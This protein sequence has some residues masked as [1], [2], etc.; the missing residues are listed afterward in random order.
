MVGPLRVDVE[1]LVKISE[2]RIDLGPLEETLGAIVIFCNQENEAR[3]EMNKKFKAQMNSL[4][5]RLEKMDEALKK[6]PMMPVLN[7]LENSHRHD[8]VD[9]GGHESH[10]VAEGTAQ[11]IS[12]SG[13]F[14]SPTQLRSPKGSASASSTATQG[15]N[16]A[17]VVVTASPRLLSPRAPH[18][19]ISPR[20]DEVDEEREAR[21]S[22]LE[23]SADKMKHNIASVDVVHLDQAVKALEDKHERLES[24]IADVD[25]KLHRLRAEQQQ[26]NED[27]SRIKQQLGDA[28]VQKMSRH[29]KE[30]LL[31]QATDE[32]ENAKRAQLLDSL[33]ES[34]ERLQKE[35]GDVRHQS[36][37]V[38]IQQLEHTQAMHTQQL[39]ELREDNDEQQALIAGSFAKIDKLYEELASAAADSEQR[40]ELQRQQSYRTSTTAEQTKARLEMM[41]EQ[42]QDFRELKEL[43]EVI[44]E[45][46]AEIPELKVARHELLAIQ[47][48]VEE[49]ENSQLDIKSLQRDV[50]DHSH[51]NQEQSKSLEILASRANAADQRFQSFAQSLLALHQ[52]LGEHALDLQWLFTQA[53]WMKTSL[54]E[55]QERAFVKLPTRP[56]SPQRLQYVKVTPA[57]VP[58]L[59]PLSA[60]VY[61]LGAM[62]WS[63]PEENAGNAAKLNRSVNEAI[64]PA[65]KHLGRPL[66][67]SS[68]RKPRTLC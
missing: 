4:E 59:P 37:G 60:E 26:D 43:S 6:R 12:N 53:R 42:M 10:D 62:K 50:M 33:L 29:V 66:S 1:D 22:V 16:A 30:L 36:A 20:Q 47:R 49:L 45:I 58:N 25:A 15:E 65:A 8:A 61:A 2:P 44:Y 19:Y 27:F 48:A 38:D 3:K 64:T 18:P 67:A 14:L 11:I 13:C 52:V 54:E 34:T 9:K 68:V 63:G 56:P 31:R 24:V 40:I 5:D 46:K 55:V 28:D 32:A 51:T 41:E 21:L 57:G 23:M 17:T 39:K 35:I 7:L